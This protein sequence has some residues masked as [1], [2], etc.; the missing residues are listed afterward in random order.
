MLAVLSVSGRAER[1]VCHRGKSTTSTTFG[2][3]AGH[4]EADTYGGLTEDDVL[5]RTY[6]G[7]TEGELTQ[8]E[9]D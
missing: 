3:A 1:I 5:R 6:L 4:E 2:A 9:A 8:E 7:L